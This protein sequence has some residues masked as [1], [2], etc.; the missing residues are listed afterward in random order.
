M[1]RERELDVNI[2]KIDKHFIDKLR[3]THPE[4]AITCDIISMAHKLGHLAVAEG[5]EEKRQFIYLKE[6]ECDRIQGY[7][8]SKPLSEEGVLEFLREY[9]EVRSLT[10]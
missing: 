7:F 6:W 1:A 2:L 5:V 3:V 10:L 9:R 4:N 8:I